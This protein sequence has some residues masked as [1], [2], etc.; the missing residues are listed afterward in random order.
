MTRALGGS[1]DV[2]EDVGRL[3]EI[4]LKAATGGRANSWKL[5]EKSSINPTP[6]KRHIVVYG[7]NLILVKVNK[8]SI[9][10][11]HRY[12]LPPNYLYELGKSTSINR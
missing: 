11:G 4:I 7:S 8:R 5:G 10:K 1:L 6:K 2:R 9:R 12:Q 3:Q